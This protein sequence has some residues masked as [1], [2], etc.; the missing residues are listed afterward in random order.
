MLGEILLPVLE[1]LTPVFEALAIGMAYVINVIIGVAN[2]VI[3]LINLIPSV[4]IPAMNYIDIAKLKEGFENTEESGYSSG[5]TT[6][7][8]NQPITNNFTITFTGNT[9]LDTDDK[10]LEVLSD[11]LISYWK[12]KGVK[13]FA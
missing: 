10:S 8:W 11:R 13:V 12:D 1:A 2:T 4:N 6:A 9:V 3:S 7:G 5:S